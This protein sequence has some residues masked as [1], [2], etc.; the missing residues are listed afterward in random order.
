[1]LDE[2]GLLK[3]AKQKFQLNIINFLQEIKQKQ[4]HAVIKKNQLEIMG[5][6]KYYSRRK[7]LK[8]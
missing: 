3:T 1:M 2:A 4:E 6:E 7:E 5:M 8:R